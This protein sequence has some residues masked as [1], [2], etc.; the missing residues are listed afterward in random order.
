MTL[1][2]LATD[3]I[4][5][6]CPT[7]KKIY[8]IFEKLQNSWPKTFNFERINKEQIEQLRQIKATQNEVSIKIKIENIEFDISKENPTF[9]GSMSENRR[10]SPPP[11]RFSWCF[12]WA[13]GGRVNRKGFLQVRGVHGKFVFVYFTFQSILRPLNI[14]TKN[15]YFFMK[16]LKPLRIKESITFFTQQCTLFN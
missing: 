13:G 16:M 15:T 8:F 1:S 4:F 9:Y 11:S 2:K 6:P 5:R 7:L 10:T 3:R 12:L 14:K